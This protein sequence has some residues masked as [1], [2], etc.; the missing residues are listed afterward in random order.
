MTIKIHE[1]TIGN[2][3]EILRSDKPVIVDFW[4]NW[5]APCHAMTPT[6]K[7][8]AKEFEDQVT[9]AKVNVDSNRDLASQFKVR[10]IPTI[11]LFK[12]GKEWDRFSGVK[13]HSEMK[14]IVER[15]VG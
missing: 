5:C 3:S 14:K 1:A 10:S 9:F 12:H 2:I 13:N 15:L 4:A 8:V 6:L 11:I 7:R